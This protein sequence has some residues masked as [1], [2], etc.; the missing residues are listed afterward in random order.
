MKKKKKRKKNKALVSFYI[1]HVNQQLIMILDFR[2][3]QM[4]LLAQRTIKFGI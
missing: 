3:T 1:K 4:R 2:E